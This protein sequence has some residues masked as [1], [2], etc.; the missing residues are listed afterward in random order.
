MD[1]RRLLCWL[2]F[3]S[4]AGVITLIPNYFAEESVE[5]ILQPQTSSTSEQGPL[6]GLRSGE[7]PAPSLATAQP[8][9]TSLPHSDL[10]AAHS[11]YVAPA[12]Q[13]VVFVPAAAPVQQAPVSP[14]L[15]FVFL[16]K[17]DDNQRL[18]V[19]LLRGETIFTVS[20]G[21]VIEG[22]Y[23]VERISGTEMT[24]V[25]L[26]LNSTQSLSVGSSL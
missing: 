4:V 22:T 21:D 7:Q 14:P 11:W 24:L 2:V 17:L 3:F 19:F 13:P 26:P 8:A 9:L 12:L 23:R 5:P 16:G 20:V 18:R 10:F 25:Y 1:T 15:P 6:S